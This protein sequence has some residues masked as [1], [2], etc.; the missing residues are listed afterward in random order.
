MDPAGK[1]EYHSNARLVREEPKNFNKYDS[2]AAKSP[3]TLIS[4]P[5]ELVEL[6]GFGDAWRQSFH[7]MVCRVRYPI[8]IK[9]HLLPISPFSELHVD[10]LFHHELVDSGWVH[11]LRIEVGRLI[12][13]GVDNGHRWH[14]GRLLIVKLL[15]RI[16]SRRCLLLHRNMSRQDETATVV[17]RTAAARVGIELAGA[18]A[19]LWPQVTGVVARLLAARQRAGPKLQLTPRS[20][21]GRLLSPQP[22]GISSIM[23]GSIGATGGISRRVPPGVISGGGGGGGM[24]S[25]PPLPWAVTMLALTTIICAAGAFSFP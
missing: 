5:I 1:L 23:A 14:R 12:D 13:R 20:L 18:A 10:Q 17:G 9:S 7:G 21:E 8:C 19:E 25:L 11:L 24:S 3:I 4:S 16:V 6:W 2:S 15:L 22:L